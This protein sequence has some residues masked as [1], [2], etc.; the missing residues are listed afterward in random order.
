MAKLIPR[1][2]NPDHTRRGDFLDQ[3]LGGRPQQIMG[4]GM[5]HSPMNKIIRYGVRK[6]GVGC[7]KIGRGL[8]KDSTIG[9]IPNHHN[10]HLD[11]GLL[12][13]ATM[14]Q[15]NGCGDTE[16]KTENMHMN[17]GSGFVD[18]VKKHFD[19]A[20]K[21]GG[22][23]EDYSYAKI[24]A[25]SAQ[26]EPSEE[27][28]R[29]EVVPSKQLSR[30]EIIQQNNQNKNV[31][32]NPLNL[33]I[34]QGASGPSGTSP[35]DDPVNHADPIQ[36][37][38]DQAMKEMTKHTLSSSERKKKLRFKGLGEDEKRYKKLKKALNMC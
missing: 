36:N 22:A 29:G 32:T 2:Y 24:K 19:H 11:H 18:D 31:A 25:E 27:F 3:T 34:A 1:S 17:K 14:G 10:K 38:V 13:D 35:Y 6:S 37:E 33:A 16:V 26:H 12:Q 8:F 7:H 21:K 23:L 5:S 4:I 15:V 9:G 30:E 20:E 28:L